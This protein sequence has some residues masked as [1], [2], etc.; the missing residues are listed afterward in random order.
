M[1]ELIFINCKSTGLATLCVG[2]GM[3]VSTIVE[4]VQKM[5]YAVDNNNKIEVSTSGQLAFCEGCNSEVKGR[6]G[7]KNIAHWYHINKNECDSWYEPITKWHLDWQNI[8]PLKN[9]EVTLFDNETNIY[10]RA[11]IQLD[12][13]LV[14]EVQNSNINVDEIKQ[15]EDF[16]KKNGLIWIL[17][18]ETLVSKS[19][20]H[21][22]Y[23]QKDLSIS[24]VIP[25]YIEEEFI[26][27]YSFDDVN[28]KFRESYSYNKANSH[29]E[30]LKYTNENGNYHYFDFKNSISFIHL[31]QEFISDLR[32]IY[33]RLYGANFENKL[34]ANT[35]IKYNCIENDYYQVLS[36]I[37]KYWKTF[38]DEIKSPIFIDNLSGLSNDLIYSYQENKIYTK[39]F[40]LKEI[41]KK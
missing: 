1:I 23:V 29:A 9:R 7:F 5:R 40:F 4:L 34:I 3:G 13:G 22:R 36:F 17:N 12:N 25:E 16:Y 2:G 30:F 37:K 14:I 18:G 35:E 11:D 6:K 27:G 19:K 21:Y 32:V 38:I 8:F 15:R 33:R 28:E 10:H 24:I 20:L 41:I 26:Y 39:E 31:R